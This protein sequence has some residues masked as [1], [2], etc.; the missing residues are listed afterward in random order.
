MP[1]YFSLQ[2]KTVVNHVTT[3]LK[4][5]N[6][7]IRLVFCS[8]CVGMGFDSPSITKV[9]H[10]KPPR[11][12]LDLVQQAGR[13]GRSSQACTSFVYFNRSDI[14]KNV[15]GMTD[16][17]REYCITDQCLRICMLK[18]FGYQTPLQ[19]MSGCKCCKNCKLTCQC[20]NPSVAVDAI[21]AAAPDNQRMESFDVEDIFAFC[22]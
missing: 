22:S 3:D 9:I 18:V 8:S 4:K 5:V 21:P 1:Y 7:R 2:D 11:N 10:G 12:M 13:S 20:C 16:D 15:P 14:A 17:M 19:K 6:P